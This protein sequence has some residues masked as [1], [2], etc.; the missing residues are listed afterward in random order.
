MHIWIDADAC[1]AAIK[2]L[3][4]RAAER[5][6]T[7]VTLVANNSVATPTSELF[8]SIVVPATPDAAD[9]RIVELM[10]PGDLVITADVP[11]AA[12]AVGQGGTALNPRGQHY[13]ADTVGDALATRDLLTDLRGAGHVTGGP[14]GFSPKHK[15]AFANQLD[16]LLARAA[17]GR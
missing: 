9:H 10:A 15:Q 16:R 12:A 7:R 6:R 2:D 1:P 13:T 4:F 5:T 3:L 11:L 8:E 17:R 14:A